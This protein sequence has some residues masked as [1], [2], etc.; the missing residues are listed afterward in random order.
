MHRRDSR[1]TISDCM[2]EGPHIDVGE[3]GSSAGEVHTALMTGEG[4]PPRPFWL[5]VGDSAFHITDENR[6]A[7][8]LGMLLWLSVKDHLG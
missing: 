7:L 5:Q 4:L 8:S 2:S 3:I 1:A 6:D